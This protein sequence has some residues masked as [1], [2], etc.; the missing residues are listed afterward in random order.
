MRRFVLLIAFLLFTSPAFAV[1]GDSCS[2]SYGS[3]GSSIDSLGE[4]CGQLTPLAN[5][6]LSATVS[7]SGGTIS[8]TTISLTDATNFPS[9]GIAD[10]RNN[11]GNRNVFLYTGKSGNNLTGVTN[12]TNGSNTTC[13]T[14]YTVA[15]GGR[16]Y[17]L[18]TDTSL[19]ARLNV[20]Q[21]AVRN[22]QE[23]VGLN[24][25]SVSSLGVSTCSAAASAIGSSAA[26]ILVM[27]GTLTA[28]SCTLTA[29]IVIQCQGGLIDANSAATAVTHLGPIICPGQ[30][31]FTDF[32]SNSVSFA[33]NTRV[34]YIEPAWWGAIGD[35]ATNSVAA[36]TAAQVACNTAGG[37]IIQ[38]A[39]G[40]YLFN[41]GLTLQGTECILRGMGKGVTTITPG[42]IANTIVTGTTASTGWGLEDLTILPGT[43][44]ALNTD[45]AYSQ[46][47]AVR[48]VAFDLTNGNRNGIS[49][50]GVAGL[51][52]EDSDFFSDGEAGG[53]GINL[54]RHT[55]DLVVRRNTFRFLNKGVII[56]GGT[57]GEEPS[58][59]ITIVDNLFDMGWFL[60]KAQYS[61]SGG[62]V[63]YAAG[64]LTDSAQSF[65]AL[66]SGTPI[67]VYTTK[68][69]SGGTVTY[70]SSGSFIT[71]ASANFT[72][73]GVGRGDIVFS[74]STSSTKWAPVLYAKSATVLVV[75]DWF[76]MTTW[77]P[78][79]SP[80]ANTSYVVNGIT[81][82][83][84]GSNTGTAITLG[85]ASAVWRTWTGATA[86]TPADG[87]AY[88]V[89]YVTNYPILFED[90]VDQF[91]V[92]RNTL[93][94]CWT[95]C[96]G[97][98]GAGYGTINENTVEDGRDVGITANGPYIRIV[99]NTI[100]HQGACGISPSAQDFLVQG[101]SIT[102][103]PWVNTANTTSLGGICAFTGTARG[104]IVDNILDGGTSPIARHA[105]MLRTTSE[106]T[107]R[108]NQTQNHTVGSLRFDTT[109]GAPA[110]TIVLQNSFSEGLISDGGAT[111]TIWQFTQ[112]FTFATLPTM[113]NGSIL[114][115]SDCTIANPCAGSGTGAFLKRLNGVNVCN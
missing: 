56:D 82:G 105:I 95:D 49:S 15:L 90:G 70:S 7:C 59:G 91:T 32:A 78:T 16:V 93:R 17:A 37:G 22:T 113:A 68:Q 108:G 28:S 99:N 102:N 11:T 48:R 10:V 109:G 35:G 85:N 4:L 84:R 30:Q 27:D 73:N 66:T 34:G 55:Q 6:T 67:R 107:V 51:L 94:R 29:N 1:D 101:N 47:I 31:L 112:P 65:A 76:D 97:A 43:T 18:S 45:G 114:F 92:S 88:E 111:G 20:L 80:A 19:P 33:G 36:V 14:D 39:A 71:D 110:D 21:D 98:Q 41:T 62:T 61:G 26:T 75:E 79:T 3:A 54:I 38:L 63:T 40:N 72:G 23:T 100:D 2:S 77:Q 64:T 103:T 60:T 50:Q 13:T 52:V 58:H 5:S 86:S 89:G 46:R 12:G 69:S 8:S 115:C 24:V 106:V 53:T 87:S 81:F 104:L 57:A 44:A 25:V 74:P 96:I 9:A 83:E 42:S